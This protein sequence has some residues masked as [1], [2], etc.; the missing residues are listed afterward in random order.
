MSNVEWSAYMEVS[1]TDGK[2]LLNPLS[3]KNGNQVDNL[4][5]MM[6][7]FQDHQID[8]K[9]RILIYKSFCGSGKCVDKDTLILTNKG[10][11]RIED[12]VKTD[13]HAQ[14]TIEESLTDDLFAIDKDKYIGS[15]VK[16]L[17]LNSF[18]I[19][20]DIISNIFDM[21]EEDIV[22]ITTNSGFNIKCTQTHKL[23]ILDN[24]CN[25]IFKE[26]KDI[27]IGDSIALVTSTEIYGED[28]DILGFYQSDFYRRYKTNSKN[29]IIPD[30]MNVEI[31]ELLGY[32][33]SEGGDSYE[34][35]ITITNDEQIIRD[36]IS[37]I[38]GKLGIYAS[39][40]FDHERRMYDGNNITSVMLNNITSVM[41]NNITEVMFYDFVFY[42]GY[43]S[44]SKNKEVPWSI[45]Q[46][47]KKIQIAFLKAL[48][49]GD[50]YIGNENTN[51]IEYYT[52]SK[53]MA[54]QLHLMLLNMGIFSSLNEKA[55]VCVK[56]DGERKDC[57]ICYRISISGRYD[58]IR[59]IN[60]I[61]FIQDYKKNRCIE[62]LER[63]K[64]R[65]ESG[66][67]S[68]SSRTINGS[69]IRLKR[70][71]EEFK[72]LGK[73]RKII[74][75][76]NE[77]IYLGDRTWKVARH[78]EL[79]SKAAIIDRGLK[80]GNIEEW[81]NGSY[82][83]SKSQTLKLLKIM[84]ECY[85][86][87]DFKYLY[88][89]ATSNIEFDTI[90]DKTVENG[91]V[92]DLT[93]RDNHSY[94]GNGF[95]N[96][97][98][99]TL[100]HV[101]K[102]LEGRAIFVTPFKNL[103]RQ[104]YSDYFKGD[105]FVMKKDGTKLKVS[106]FLGRN[107]FVCKY[108]EEQYDYQQKIIEANKKF[109][110]SIPIDDDILKSY[111]I[112]KTT[113]NRFLPC[114][115]ML[116]SIG[117]IRREPRYAVA[118]NCQYWIPP[119]IPK[120]IIL[121]WAES[122]ES[123]VEESYEMDGVN[124]QQTKDD[125]KTVDKH[126]S[127]LDKIKAMIKCSNIAYYDS[128]GQ[129][130]MGIFIRDEKDKDGKPCSEVCPY[131]K[132]FYSYVDSD[133]IVFNSSKW[134][135][136]TLMGRKPK[137]H[138]E[139]IDEGDYWLDNQA[140]TIELMRS[141]IDKIFPASNKMK[142][143]KT[144]A[145]TNF[146][147]FFRK[148]KF[149]IEKTKTNGVNIINTKDYKV[150]FYTI[151]VFLEEY[152]K[153]NEDDDTIDQ[154]I[155]DI[156]MIRQYADVASLSYIEGKREESKIIKV[157]IP[158]P[159]KLL[160]TLFKFSSKNLIITSGTM[161]GNPVLSNLFGINADNYVVDILNGRKEHP[162]KLICIRPPKE[163]PLNMVK[164]T[165]TTWQSPE[166]KE[167]Y[168]KLLNYILDQLKVGI[169]KKTGKPGEAK[170]LVLT[171]AKKY[172]EGILKRSD[173][174]VDFA[175]G[176]NGNEENDIKVAINT[177]LTDYV[178]STLADVRKIKSS[179]IELDGDV[180]RTNKQI[181]V[182]TRMIR[183]SDLRDDKCRAIVMTKWPVGDI[184]DGYLQAIKKRFGDKTFWD[185]VRDKAARE[186]VQYVSRGLRHEYDWCLF[187]TPDSMAFDQVFRLF[188]YDN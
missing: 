139:V 179:D 2:V 8:E 141:T 52:I 41:L 49:S 151:K 31:A 115:K 38:V 46:S 44:G 61:G 96:H 29:I 40:I 105:K 91:H 74:K 64:Y 9:T 160:K 66:I 175:K 109:D 42:L 11:L 51:Y 165:Y 72:K 188:S 130:E 77:E 81:I 182:S 133:V 19:E 135:L 112:D 164:V 166:F 168:F 89:I 17:N 21:G 143:I 13:S 120:K 34:K 23:I 30:K 97:N 84:K 76:W 134:N 163:S 6:K 93:I 24:E 119:P 172:T 83:A 70:I 63:L 174:F 111:Q 15:T 59:Y 65:E 178:D 80:G 73:N 53:R 100:L 127:Q 153:Q 156:N 161:H 18:K 121:K 118:K 173:V 56:K 162:G 145:L 103:Q 57:G 12:I 107:N 125:M 48:F 28:V 137:V 60:I 177:N 7:F 4:R 158:F 102:E 32:I 45:L 82:S 171:P 184:S 167:Y 5:T 106:V 152:K 128:V 140:T 136:E 1:G 25:I 71:Y 54:E 90:V 69:Y 129:D 99:L 123:N 55:S 154:K 181:I 35:V 131:Y 138:V 39:E 68:Y 110:Q 108:L 36:R 114:T 86:M 94:I 149:D 155:I 148:I 132:Q 101:P 3:W 92:Y 185:I 147:M 62:L 187:A 58:I 50:G 79:S 47:S 14:K 95:I 142:Q 169:D 20:N 75:T 26:A 113:A 33:I 150:L 43:I 104:Y 157:Y 180:F 88:N 122:S 183:G 78:K 186:A 170:I 10:I 126:V 124:E 98:S 117:G 22:S 27:S 176:R 146:D 67:K 144:D 116:R 85:Y 87:E 37:T 159:D 16:S